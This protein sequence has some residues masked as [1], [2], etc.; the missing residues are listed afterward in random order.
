MITSKNRI[1]GWIIFSAI[2]SSIIFYVLLYA[3]SKWFPSWTGRSLSNDWTLVVISAI[4]ILVVLIFLIV[5][6]MTKAKFGDL[7]LEFGTTISPSLIDIEDFE[8]EPI[9]GSVNKENEVNLPK[10]VSNLR[11]QS[12]NVKTLLVTLDSQGERVCFRVLRRYIFELSKVPSVEYVVF[13][14][15]SKQYIGFITIENFIKRYPRFGVEVLVDDLRDRWVSEKM[16]DAGIPLLTDNEQIVA[17]RNLAYTLVNSLWVG[18]DTGEGIRTTDL[19]KLGA[20]EI[21]AFASWPIERI[22]SLLLTNNIDGIPIISKEMSFI[23]I[24]T[25]EKI[26]KTVI[27]RLLE[28]AG[29]REK[30][31]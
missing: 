15:E 5:D 21:S 23:G 31:A 24:V 2:F 16:I 14:N 26:S 12:S 28:N 11:Q 29:N 8:R 9:T 19:H 4:P 20:M 7:E 6:R 17:Y 18:E 22:Y 3:F 13:L 10:L 1:S 27:L 25:Q 30:K